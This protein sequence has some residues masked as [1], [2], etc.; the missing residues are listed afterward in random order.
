[1]LTKPL[2]KTGGFLSFHMS[3]LFVVGTKVGIALGGKGIL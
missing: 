2:V 1:V 3:D